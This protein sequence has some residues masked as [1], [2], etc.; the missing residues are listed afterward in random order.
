ME[1]R[2]VEREYLDGDLRRL[3]ADPDFRPA[4]WS[5][6]EVR[7]FHRLVQCVR[8]AHVESDLRNLRVLRIVPD[9]SGDSTRA[10]ATLGSARVIELTFK[11][12]GSHSAVVFGIL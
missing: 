3:A 4:G 6:R 12:S 1:S 7:E 2:R 8:A 11:N 9:N 10:R 5:D